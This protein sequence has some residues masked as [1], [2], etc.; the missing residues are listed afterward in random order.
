MLCLERKTRNKVR[1]AHLP[2][3][4]KTSV[5]ANWRK[6]HGA[7]KSR[8]YFGKL[9]NLFNAAHLGTMLK[10]PDV[11]YVAKLRQKHRKQRIKAGDPERI[12]KPC[13]SSNSAFLKIRFSKL[14]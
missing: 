6:L 1:H 3:S 13:K 11:N 2:N 5:L 12:I 10:T 4:I 8:A 7:T 14:A 9:F